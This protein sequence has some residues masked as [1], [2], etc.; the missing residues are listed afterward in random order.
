MKQS[1]VSVRLQIHNNLTMGTIYNVIGKLHGNQEKDRIVLLGNHRDAWV[2][3][4]GDPN[5]GT[6][7]MMEIARVLGAYR[8]HHKYRP[9][10]SVWFG[11]WDAEEFGLIGSSEWAEQERQVISQRVVAYLN[12]DVIV[13]GMDSLRASTT[14]NLKS[15]LYKVSQQVQDPN[16]PGQTLYST[17]AKTFVAPPEIGKNIPDVSPLGSGSDYTPFLQHLGVS[18]FDIRFSARP[19]LNLSSYPVYHSIHDTFDWTIRFNDPRMLKHRAITQVWIACAVFLADMPLLPL[20]LVDYSMQIRFYL[21]RI[22]NLY[23]QDFQ[24]NGIDFQLLLDSV[25]KFH[26]GCQD[27]HGKIE[28]EM[29]SSASHSEGVRE[30]SLRKINDILM[31]LERAFLIPDGLAER[32]WYRHAI[33]APTRHNSYAG[34]VFPSIVDSIADKD[35][36]NLRIQIS[37]VAGLFDSATS[38]FQI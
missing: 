16:L 3:G 9:R 10:R 20:S 2:Y 7:A 34:A 11:S 33:F 23:Q 31:L 17:W 18:A 25:E 14:P 35:W 1:L 37:L 27:F 13:A 36:E 30:L 8:K 38:S 22:V 24:E 29:V 19:Q 15:L 26:K 12:V 21:D 4:A 32:R 6:A 28:Q 5:G